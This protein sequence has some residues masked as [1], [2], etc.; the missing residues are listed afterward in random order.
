MS[1]HEK[2]ART[3]KVLKILA[4]IPQGDTAEANGRAADL[5]AA[6]PQIDRDLLAAQAGQK[7]PSA[8]TWRQVVEA[9]RMRRPVAELL[10]RAGRSEARNGG[11]Q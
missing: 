8:E 2:S 6:L 7:V 10:A 4:V 5:L 11:V 1:H 3:V 9:V